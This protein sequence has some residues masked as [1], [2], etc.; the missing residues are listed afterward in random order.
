MYPHMVSKQ[1]R[2][3]VND[4][5]KYIIEYELHV[6]KEKFMQDCQKYS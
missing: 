1:R 2:L 4:S 3:I 6:K 5:F